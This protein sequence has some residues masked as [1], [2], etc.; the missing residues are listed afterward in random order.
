MVKASAP[1]KVFLIGEH[2]VVYGEPAILSAVGARCFVEAEKSRDSNVSV[3]TSTD[4]N[5]EFSVE[6]CREY[7]RRLKE[8][9]EECNKRTD[10]S[11]IINEFKKDWRNYYRVG[12]GFILEEFGIGEG[13]RIIIESRIPIGSGMGFSAAFSVA[14]IKALSELFG[15]G[16]S[17]EEVND[18]AYRIEKLN[19][20]KPSG[21]DNSTCTFGGLLWFQ[22]EEGKPVIN[23]LRE[24]I[25]H[26]FD[27]FVIVN[28]GS[29]EMTT[30]ELV[31]KVRNL[32]E[33][34]RTPRVKRL[35]ELTL[36]MKKALKEKDMESVKEVL[37]EAQ[38]NLTELG[39]SNRN[40]DKIS[41]NVMGIGGGAKLCGAGGGGIML[42]YHEDKERL[43]KL[44]ESLGFEIIEA[45]LGS[46]GARIEG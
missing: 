45:E 29:P 24:E 10:F 33:D 13:V 16:L 14:S 9:W 15:K 21:A 19:H 2:A 46:E 20:G 35:G 7:A 36:K 38:K 3:K 12:I 42:C 32:R 26:R 44:I 5:L 22:R 30:G 1:G 39:V 8:M 18:L 31:Q 43:V 37:N 27:D 4:H 17:Q 23:S 41:E 6:E 40:L 34:Y 28:T 25:T 11:E